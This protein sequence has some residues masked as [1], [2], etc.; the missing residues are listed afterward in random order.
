MLNVPLRLTSST[1]SKASSPM[2][3]SRPSRVMPALL[4]SAQMEPKVV[5]DR[6]HARVDGSGVG[7]VALICACRGASRP[8]RLR[9]SRAPHRRFRHRRRRYQSRPPPDRQR[10]RGRYPREPPVTSAT[11]RESLR[12]SVP[13]FKLPMSFLSGYSPVDYASSSAIAATCSA[14]SHEYTRTSLNVRL[15]RPDSVLPGPTSINVSI[16]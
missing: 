9:T 2:R 7:H 14:V 4:T 11:R 1:R 13:L 5:E 3:M 12:S 16:P 8:R 15:T 6:F 10:R